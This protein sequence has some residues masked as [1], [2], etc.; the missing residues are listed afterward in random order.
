M[1]DISA[2]DSLNDSERVYSLLAK[3]IDA[4]LGEV[5]LDNRFWHRGD[6]I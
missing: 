5:K 1:F 2:S 6:A 3:Y 4:T